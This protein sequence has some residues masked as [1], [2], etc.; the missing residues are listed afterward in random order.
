MRKYKMLLILLMIGSLA[1]EAQQI[2]GKWKVIDEDSGEAKCIIDIFKTDNNT[3]KG[4]IIKLLDSDAP[5]DATCIK[6]KGK[7]KDE[8]LVGLPILRGFTKENDKWVDG[9]ITDPEKGKTYDSKIWVDED[10]PDKLK[11]R[12]YV[13]IFYRT[14]TWERVED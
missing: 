2:T 13:S 1:T 4:E 14:Q 3:L 12:G 5:K 7:F 8:P 9:K 6:C 10:D 11:V